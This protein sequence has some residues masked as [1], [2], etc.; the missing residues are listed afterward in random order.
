MGYTLSV[1]HQLPWG[2]VTYTSM[3]IVCEVGKVKR[4]F[5]TCSCFKY[6][7]GKRDW[8]AKLWD[9]MY[10]EI[11]ALFS[12]YRKGQWNTASVVFNYINALKVWLTVGWFVCCIWPVSSVKNMGNLQSSAW[13][14]YDH[15]SPVLKV[16]VSSKHC[17]KA[18]LAVRQEMTSQKA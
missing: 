1:C 17:V 9:T 7:K 4:G 16:I 15:R 2:V 5:Q 8:P 13:I 11:F 18:F 10:M 12:Q 3:G 6:E 14:A